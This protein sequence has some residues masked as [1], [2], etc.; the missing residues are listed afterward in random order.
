Q[1]AIQELTDRESED[2]DAHRHLHLADA[3][4]EVAPR[5]GQGRH[6]DMHGERAAEGKQSKQPKW[7][8][9]GRPFRDHGSDGHAAISSL[10]FSSALQT[11]ERTRKAVSIS[12]SLRPARASRRTCRAA[13][14]TLSA[15]ARPRAVRKIALA[16]RSL[17][18]SRRLIRPA[19]SKL[20]SSRTTDE[21][22]SESEAAR[23]F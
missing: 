13:T 7:C 18:S 11:C 4:A 9:A 21:P 20:S 10:D 2:V 15:M 5:L 23:S 6:E 12:R 22:S 1:W 14:S 19:A 3:G 17:A 16:R 8:R